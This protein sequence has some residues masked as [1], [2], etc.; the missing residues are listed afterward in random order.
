ML[1]SR[2]S[3]IVPAQEE[4]FG[5]RCDFNCDQIHDNLFDVWEN[6]HTHAYIM[7]KLQWMPQLS[8]SGEHP[9]KTKRKATCVLDIHR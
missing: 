9:N 5:R 4:T 2:N 8:N 7:Q 1:S 6:M 3:G